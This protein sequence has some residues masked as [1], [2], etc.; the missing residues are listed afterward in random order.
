MSARRHRRRRPSPL[1]DAALSL[2]DGADERMALLTWL[3]L[4]RPDP[5]IAGTYRSY[6]TELEGYYHA[7]LPVAPPSQKT[8][9]TGHE[10]RDK[11]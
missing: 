9:D 11:N 7:F 6:R 5:P 2:W 4:F 3:F 10:T 1:D 8:G